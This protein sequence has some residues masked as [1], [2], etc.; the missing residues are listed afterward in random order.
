MAIYRS[1]LTTWP[2]GG[3]VALMN[4]TPKAPEGLDTDALVRRRLGNTLLH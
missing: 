1:D 3:I 4:S 2:I